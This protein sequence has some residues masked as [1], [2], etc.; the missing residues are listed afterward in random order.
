MMADSPC[1]IEQHEYV[2]KALDDVVVR[3]MNDADEV[4]CVK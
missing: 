3:K 4:S 2:P 1:G